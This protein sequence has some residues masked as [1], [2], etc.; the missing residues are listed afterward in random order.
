[1]CPLLLEE[2]GLCN[3]DNYFE[4]IALKTESSQ[5]AVTGS[6]LGP[7]LPDPHLLSSV[8]SA[9]GDLAQ[10]ISGLCSLSAL[11]FCNLYHQFLA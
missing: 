3:Q 6:T 9:S 11:A 5:L 10:P 4:P 8:L 2:N 1:M 7:S